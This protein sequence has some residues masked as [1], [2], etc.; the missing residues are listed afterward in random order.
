M[1]ARISSLLE[2]LG[3]DRIPMGSTSLKTTA[4]KRGGPNVAGDLVIWTQQ[5]PDNDV[6]F[7]GTIT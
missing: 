1:S 4:S 6:Q 3:A 5:G 7:E 2:S